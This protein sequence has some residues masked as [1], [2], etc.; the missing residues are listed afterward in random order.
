MKRMMAVILSGMLTATPLAV[1]S[2]PKGGAKKQLSQNPRAQEKQDVNGVADPPSMIPFDRTQVKLTPGFQGHDIEQLYSAVDRRKAAQR[3]DEF[4]TTPD[5]ER[6]IREEAIKPLLGS[7]FP[8]SIYA[9]RV[10]LGVSSEYDA[11]KANLTIK[12]APSS[13]YSD[14]MT[15]SRRAL[16]VLHKLGDFRQYTATNALGATVTVTES[17]A[18]W[19]ELAYANPDKSPAVTYT[20][21]L[22]KRFTNSSDALQVSVPMKS[23]A[24]RE[25]KDHIQALAICTLLEPYVYRYTFYDKP[26]FASP[27]GGYHTYFYLNVR[28]LEVWF[29]DVR[30]GMVLAKLKRQP[31][32]SG[33]GI[34]SPDSVRDLEN[35]RPSD[36]PI[37]S[38]QIDLCSA[39]LKTRQSGPPDLAHL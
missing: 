13:V 34:V 36:T 26:T 3:K 1:R 7:L 20:Q 25:S 32:E 5:Y 39:P 2:V 24:A 33:K 23:Q 27:H 10:V 30:T 17:R 9:F 29:Y 16:R 15:E 11:D 22:L 21:K 37:L 18:E 14:D 38:Q 31:E 8:D 12:L 19:Y 35:A 28:L 4:E 6:R